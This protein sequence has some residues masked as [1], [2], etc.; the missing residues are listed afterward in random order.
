MKMTKIYKTPDIKKTPL[1][2]T[3]I[4]KALRS[5]GNDATSYKGNQLHSVI[6]VA[7]IPS[8]SAIDTYGI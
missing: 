8:G 4:F 2:K 7:N 1:D 3:Q 5:V 6:S